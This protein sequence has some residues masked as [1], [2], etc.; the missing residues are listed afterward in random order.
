MH[1]KAGINQWVRV[2]SGKESVASLAKAASEVLA[3]H[4]WECETAEADA[5]DWGSDDE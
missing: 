2:V 5:A 3:V 1:G 4:G